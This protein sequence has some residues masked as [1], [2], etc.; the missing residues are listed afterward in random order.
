MPRV[1]Q[2][3]LSEHFPFRSRHER[4]EVL[5]GQLRERL[6]EV[7]IEIP[8]RFVAGLLLLERLLLRGVLG[9]LLLLQLVLKQEHLLLLLLLLVLLRL[10]L[11][12][13]RLRMKDGCQHHTL[14]SGPHRQQL[15]PPRRLL[16]PRGHRGRRHII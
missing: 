7:R 3:V 10:L 13:L 2:N 1:R 12:L 8:G 4:G 11:L 5:G 16:S 6:L 9:L 15:R 14:P